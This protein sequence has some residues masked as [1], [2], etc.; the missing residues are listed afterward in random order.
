MNKIKKPELLAPAGDWRMLTTAVNNGADAV[1]FGVEVLNMRAKARN[2]KTSELPEIVSFCKDKNVDTHLTLNTIVYENEIPEIDQVLSA[3]KSAGINMIICWDMSV[4]QKCKEYE[5]PFCISTQASISNSLSAKFYKE[6]GASRIVL[7]RE[8]TLEKIKEIKNKVDIEIETFVHGAMCIAVSGRC[9]MSHYMFGKSA[10]RGECI[11]PCR[12]EYEITDKDSGQKLI[13]GD[14]YVLSPKDLNTIVFIDKLI[15]SG[16]DSFKIEG[17]KRSPEYIAKVIST[18]RKAI[19]LYYEDSLTEEKKQL[20]FGDLE[21]VYNRGFST[22]FYFGVPGAE[23]YATQYGSMAKTKK[24]Y[25]GKVLNYFKKSGVAHL[26]LEAENLEIGDEIY[27]IGNKTG[28][29]E[30]TVDSLVKDDVNL[31]VGKKGEDVTIKLN[32]T[33]RPKDQLFK[34]VSV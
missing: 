22:G 2:F 18:Y 1:Y 10:N 12:R 4:I 6:L 15:E 29:V 33:V 31:Q 20:M 23:D 11:Q 24:I 21:R 8:C 3:A 26:K 14:D 32:M 28:V 34:I 5:M 27:I 25:V 17:R 13:L 16:I 19:D 9:F 30:S 7:A